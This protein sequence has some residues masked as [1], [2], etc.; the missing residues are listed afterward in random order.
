MTVP[1]GR[2]IKSLAA[3]RTAIRHATSVLLTI[4][5]AVLTASSAHADESDDATFL[6]VLL[7]ADTADRTTGDSVEV[8]L[9][10]VRHLLQSGIPSTR[11]RVTELKGKNA[12]PENILNYYRKLS[13]RPTDSLLFYYAGHGAW[14]TKGHYLVLQGDGRIRRTDI[15][16]AM[17]R[18]KAQ[19][20]VLLTDC[21]ST[22]TGH[23]AFAKQLVA[24]PTLFRDL[25]FR[26]RGTVDITAARKGQVAVGNK[27]KGGYFTTGLADLFLFTNKADIDKNRDGIATWSE[28]ANVLQQQ[29]QEAF[30]RMRPR[31]IKLAEGQKGQTPHVFGN[32]AQSVGKP[33]PRSPHRFG[34]SVAPDR[35]G[36]RVSEVIDG[37]PAEW[38]GIRVGEVLSE[39]SYLTS[40]A[41]Q[42]RIQTR[43]AE[44]FVRGIAS[45]PGAAIL[46]CSLIEPSTGKQRL[47]R[48]RLSH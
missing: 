12:T 29:T 13:T 47:V 16:E 14:D 23:A 1:V 15:L 22:Y 31:G 24:D 5:A 41:E 37:T 39:F 4:T 35:A 28:A 3:S 20:N 17:R 25:L 8:D 7:V 38:S 34:V 6:H 10:T 18:H 2:H 42:R 32:L 40:D 21:C 36:V 30:E 44:Q 26:H 48:L 46:T 11:Y 43:T 19:L 33:I 27:L 9:Q 45:V